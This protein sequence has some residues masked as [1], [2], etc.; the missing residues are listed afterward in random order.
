MD[1]WLL[2]AV[3]VSLLVSFGLTPKVLR[4]D[5]SVYWKTAYMALL[6]VPILG[7][8]AF[9][10]LWTWP[11]TN[12]RDLMHDSFPLSNRFLNRE[13]DKRDGV[14]GLDDA[15]ADE[16]REDRELWRSRARSRRKNRKK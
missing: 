12:S 16:R 4:S 1:I 15:L 2:I 8:F 3:A 9:A 10:W 7:P 11:N 6:F 14:R 13:L 5:Q